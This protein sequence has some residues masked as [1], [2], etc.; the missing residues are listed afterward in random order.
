MKWE[1]V[2]KFLIILK[3]YYSVINVVVKKLINF[4]AFLIMC[5]H[6][7]GKR[8]DHKNALHSSDQLTFLNINLAMC[9][10]T[11]YLIIKKHYIW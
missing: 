8:K 9:Y 11:I 6:K 4:Y 2:F 7:W 1:Q 3:T 10:K 5:P